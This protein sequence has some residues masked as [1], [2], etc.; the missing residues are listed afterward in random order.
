MQKIRLKGIRSKKLTIQ[1]VS[2]NLKSYF[3]THNAQYGHIELRPRGI[4][5][6]VNKG[7]QYFV[8]AIPFYQLY[9]YNLP[10]LNIHGQ[11]KY[12]LFKNDKFLEKNSSFMQKLNQ[13]KVQ[14]DE[15]HPHIDAI[16]L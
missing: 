8:W 3:A 1:E 2:P 15:N 13:Q 10:T 9:I 4:V 11:G 14:Y 12:V 7:L 6:R 16:D 5:I